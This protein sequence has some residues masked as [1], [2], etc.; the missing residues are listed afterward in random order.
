MSVLGYRNEGG[1]LDSPGMLMVNRCTWAHCVL[2]AARLIGVPEQHLLTK[3]ELAAISGEMSPHG[4][5]IPFP[6]AV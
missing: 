4:I 1:T 3:A 2:E 6:G 5:I